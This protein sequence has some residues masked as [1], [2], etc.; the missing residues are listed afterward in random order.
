[1]EIKSAV[2]PESKRL[3]K[4][5][6]F[7]FAIALAITFGGIAANSAPED[8]IEH[9]QARMDSSADKSSRVADPAT[10]SRTSSFDERSTLDRFR[11]TPA[12]TVTAKPSALTS[13]IEALATGAQT[14]EFSDG[15]NPT[16]GASTDTA[17]TKA[18]SA[19][20]RPAVSAISHAGQKP[21]GA[22]TGINAA[23]SSDQMDLESES[24]EA[25]GSTAD[26]ET[27]A[28]MPMLTT[29]VDNMDASPAMMVE[30]N[31]AASA[32]A[33]YQTLA[34]EDDA[35][36]EDDIECPACLINLQAVA[37]TG[38]SIEVTWNKSETHP[39]L[40]LFGAAPETPLTDD[41]YRE[42]HVVKGGT[43]TFTNLTPGLVYTIAVGG[44]PDPASPD[45]SPVLVAVIAVTTEDSCDAAV[46]NFGINWLGDRPG[47]H[48]SD[49]I[50]VDLDCTDYAL[51]L[52][53]S[54]KLHKEGYQIDQTGERWRV[55]G[56]DAD[57]QTVYTSPF[58]GDLPEDQTLASMTIAQADLTGVVYFQAEH[59]SDGLVGPNVNS[60]HPLLELTPLS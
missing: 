23:Q 4:R 29:F 2:P 40:M 53:S 37:V 43:H 58:I 28:A 33:V 30:A 6:T 50:K 47:H 44:Y 13:S 11:N 27:Q 17:S 5:G 18:V 15:T 22:G 10:G 59:G 9:E 42:S 24:V 38:T 31:S 3:V 52:V 60:V 41:I 56:L 36:A 21:V 26:G 54:D 48:T 14:T 16:S 35:T 19:E 55:L 25:D 39:F 34:G 51:T 45:Q 7:L 46:V 57:G 49:S 12:A 1:M 20:K 32:N 8:T